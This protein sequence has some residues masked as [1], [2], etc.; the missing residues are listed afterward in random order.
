MLIDGAHIPILGFSTYK[1]DNAQAYAGVIAALEAGRHIDSATWYKNEAF[2]S[3]AIQDFLTKNALLCSAVF[4]TMKLKL[5]SGY[6]SA[7]AQ[8]MWAGLH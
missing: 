8:R 4:Y 5:S 6:A 2:V 7:L 1:M 3:R